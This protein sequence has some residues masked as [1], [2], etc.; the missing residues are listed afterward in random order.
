MGANHLPEV[1]GV[2]DGDGRPDQNHLFWHR[3]GNNLDLQ[4]VEIWG[5]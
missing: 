3:E 1:D 2:R 4:A 5:T